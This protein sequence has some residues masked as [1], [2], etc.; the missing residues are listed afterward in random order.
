MICQIL[1]INPERT[2]GAELQMMKTML[3]QWTDQE[4]MI[5]GSPNRKG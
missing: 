3:A 5:M 4:I 2:N 1:A